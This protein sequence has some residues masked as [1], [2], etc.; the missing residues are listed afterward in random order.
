MVFNSEGY[1][2]AAIFILI[3]DA[4]VYFCSTA[5]AGKQ[6]EQQSV[7]EDSGNKVILMFM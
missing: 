1:K 5:A 3:W 7:E 2:I 6:V 4:E